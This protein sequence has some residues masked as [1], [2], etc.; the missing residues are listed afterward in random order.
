[1]LKGCGTPTL[2]L[3]RISLAVLALSQSNIY[4]NKDKH[5]HTYIYPSRCTIY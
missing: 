2:Q 1:M 4:S 5:T 3:A